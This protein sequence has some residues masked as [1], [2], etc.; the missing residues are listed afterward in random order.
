MLVKTA[1]PQMMDSRQPPQNLQQNTKPSK[2]VIFATLQKQ[3]QS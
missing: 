3:K 1:N 2:V